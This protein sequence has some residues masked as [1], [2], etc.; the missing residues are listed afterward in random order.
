M[1]LR[2]VLLCLAVTSASCS[3]S[4]SPTAASSTSTSTSTS[5]PATILTGRV[6]RAG[7]TNGIA[8]ATMT[9][10]DSSANILTTTTDATWAFT[11]TNLSA[12]TFEL[13]AAAPGYVVSRSTLTF[14]VSSYTVQLAPEGSA[15]VSTLAV[16]IS[17]PAT[18]T[19]GQ[20]RQLTASVVYTDGSTRD[21]T[22]VATWKSTVSSVAAV[23]PTGLLTANSAGATVVSAAFAD[24]SGSFPV[25]TTSP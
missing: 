22:S 4:L 18:L 9:L 23:S 19:V 5:P 3:S 7:T 25:S 14:P 1:L 10:A 24:V 8:S 12:G 16:A 20:S 2:M 11:F 21:V 13:Q 15:P 17:G 6:V